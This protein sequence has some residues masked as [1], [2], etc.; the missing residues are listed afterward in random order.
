MSDPNLKSTSS[1]NN[2][3]DNLPPNVVNGKPLRFDI[4]EYINLSEDEI[5]D[6]DTSE[7]FLLHFSRIGQLNFVQKLLNLRD[8]KSIDLDINC[9]GASKSNLG[10]T[11]LHLAAY[12]GHIEVVE[13]LLNAGAE[14][15][16]QNEEGDTPLHRAAYTGRDRIVVLLISHNANVFLPNGDGLRPFELAKTETIRQILSAAEKADIKRRETRFLSAARNSDIATMK[17]LLEDSINPVN[18]N[19]VD[20]SGNTAL[21]C[22]AYRGKQEAVVFLLK[23]QI[24]TAVKNNREQLAANVAST[25]SLKQLIQEVHLSVMSP[26]MIASLKNRTIK[27]FEGLLLKKG[28]F[29]GWKL[30]W[31]VLERGVFSFFTNRADAANGIRRKGYKYLESAITERVNN[32]TNDEHMFIIIFGDRSRALFQ[33]P[34]SQTELDLQKWLNAI[35]DH[36]YF[37]TNFIKQGTRLIDS[38]DEDDAAKILP[39]SSIHDM[40]LTAT[41]HQKILEKHIGGLQLLVDDESL[42]TV[43]A[44]DAVIIAETSSMKSF[45]QHSNSTISNSTI[46]SVKFHLNLILESSRNANQSLVQC[47]TVISHQNEAR[48]SVIRQE[49]EKVRVLEEALQILAR[50]HHELERSII[51]NST[52]TIHDA[53][54]HI[55]GPSS[56]AASV[57]LS[58]SIMEN[59]GHQM[60]SRARSIACL[61]DSTNTDLEEFY[62]AFD[63]EDDLALTDTDV[64][65]VSNVV[66]GVGGGGGGPTYDKISLSRDSSQFTNDVL[67]DG[68]LPASM[69][70][71]INENNNTTQFHTAQS[72][73]TINDSIST[74]SPDT[75]S[76]PTLESF[77]MDGHIRPPIVILLVLCIVLVL[78][79]IET[80]NRI[81]AEQAAANRRRRSWVPSVPEPV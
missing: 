73:V 31:A 4:Q 3:D 54:N 81:A 26:Q 67:V 59:Y 48:Q 47:L 61:S 37:G 56:M 28:R 52:Q 2:K 44:D 78:I 33:L 32:C 22:A 38:D 43:T 15:D 79:G 65:D 14:V 41:A 13:S 45:G 5:V 66:V 60:S 10:W 77:E 18:I 23:N 1:K 68:I 24:D 63:D 55:N 20:S 12:F 27:R 75:D 25:I 30:I 9:K 40:I 39:M 71:P 16:V 6:Y 19:C 11:P 50:E 17:K 57:K 35:N 74:L 46:P 58:N 7:E 36:I 51:T 53:N 49:Q 70:S 8:N 42:F 64:I 69:K 21:H 62:D 34:K 29:F 72:D 80:T 76:D